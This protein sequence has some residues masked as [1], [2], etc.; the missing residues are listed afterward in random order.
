VNIVGKENEKEVLKIERQLS[1][2]L[3]DIFDTLS[4]ISKTV[5]AT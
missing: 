1:P 2:I 4:S 5:F 3:E